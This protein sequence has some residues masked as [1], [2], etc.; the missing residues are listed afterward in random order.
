[1]KHQVIVHGVCH[2]LCNINVGELNEA[3]TFRVT[4]LM[5]EI[6]ITVQMY[7]RLT[8]INLNVRI[9]NIIYIGYKIR[10]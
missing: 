4:I 6:H 8:M 1:M 9:A 3:I 5:T 10:C 2:N 7:F